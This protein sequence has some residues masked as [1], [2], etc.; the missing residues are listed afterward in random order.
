MSLLGALARI[1]AVAAGRAQPVATVRHCHVADRPMVLIP[2]KLAGEA[3]APLAVMA[4]DDERE[5]RLLVVPQP[6]SRDDRF[7]FAAELAGLLLPYVTARETGAEVLTNR[8]GDERE[9]YSD[10][11]QFLVPSRPGIGFL[12]LLGRSTR[13]RRADG[14]HPVDPSVP[15]LG[16]WLTWFADRSEHPGG[17]VLLAMTEALTLHWATGQSSLEDGSLPALL[18]WIDPPPGSTGA[19]AALRAEARPPAGPATDPA[20]DNAHLAPAI[21]DADRLREVLTTQLAPTWRLMWRGVEL[22]REL[23]EA[24]GVPARWER[25]RDSFTFFAQGLAESPPQPR[26]D[27]AVSAVRRLDRLERA[28]AAY[29]AQRAFD[30]P[31]MMAERRLAGEAFGGTVVRVDAERVNAKGRPRPHVLVHTEDAVRLRP[32]DTVYN[33]ARTGQK[34]T[35][36]EVSGEVLV[37]LT[38]GM[39]GGKTAKEGSVPGPG[40]PIC[41]CTFTAGG[42]GA[43][44]VPEAEDT[45]WTH[46]GPPAEYVPSDDDARETWS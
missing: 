5:P 33:A 25:D 44:D 1:E 38:S 29:D 32:G 27:T 17:S 13:F 46:G 31:L 14:P 22:L 23:P 16:R 15:L 35:V 20:F 12:R 18:G 21:G 10:A 6:R 4:G 28:Q 34:A 8:Q 42:A 36:V 2:L 41:F 11:P 30:D 24:A 9:R 26:R 37:E 40:D 39:G 3:A 7:A 19:E 45:P 43:T